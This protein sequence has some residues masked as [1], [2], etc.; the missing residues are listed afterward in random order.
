MGRISI[1]DL[2]R[3]K[4]RELEEFL[5]A[6]GKAHTL[7]LTRYRLHREIAAT[8]E[9]YAKGDCLDAGSGRSPYKNLL[10]QYTNHVTSFDS[11]DRSGETDVIGDIQSMTQ[12][13]D[14][15]FDT[16]LCS[17]VLEHV[18]R[19]WDAMS[20][21]ARILRPDG[22]LILSVPHLSVIH[23]APHDYYRFTRYGLQSLCDQSNLTV[24]QL[25]P[26]GGIGC[27]L[28]HG[29]SAAIMSA[30]GGIPLLRWVVFALN[31]LA[32]VRLPDLFEHYLG[33]PQLYPSDYL[34][35]ATKKDGG[36]HK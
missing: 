7:S 3:K 1:F 10:L 18:P 16:I 34:M 32:F 24:T 17:Q 6:R 4:R 15:S 20:E 5:I 22:V 11:E 8:I 25:Q 9:K 21:L 12:L 29:C 36:G 26:I 13:D 23:E 31:Y 27:F 19:P 28:L 30:L 33:M 2:L 35:V 14:A